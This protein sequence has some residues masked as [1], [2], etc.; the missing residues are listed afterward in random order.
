M[1]KWI[2]ASM[3]LLTVIAVCS[4]FLFREK[5]YCKEDLQTAVGNEKNHILMF[6]RPRLRIGMSKDDVINILGT[7]ENIDIENIWMWAILTP[8]VPN[9]KETW[10]EMNWKPAHFLVFIDGRL[11]SSELFKNAG[12]DPW[13]VTKEYGHL[14]S[15]ETIALLGPDTFGDLN[16]S[17][18]AALH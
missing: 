7:P 5:V 9:R 2:P 14:T 17:L 13:E 1:K 6:L 15:P 11:V 10:R 4:Y 16:R 8:G 3:L 18:A 12:A